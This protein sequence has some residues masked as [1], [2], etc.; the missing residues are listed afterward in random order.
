MVRT[1]CWTTDIRFNVRD[2]TPSLELL[3]TEGERKTVSGDEIHKNPDKTYFAYYLVTSLK[4][5][6]ISLLSD[7]VNVYFFNFSSLH[8][9]FNSLYSLSNIL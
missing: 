2:R 6:F 9:S 1:A 8:F 4:K 3:A 5:S 7:S